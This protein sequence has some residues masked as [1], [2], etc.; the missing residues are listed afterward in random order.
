[1]SQTLL[2]NVQDAAVSFG[3]KPL[4]EKLSF[5]ILEGERIC[6]VGK[7][8][9]GKTTLMNI[10]TGVKD[11]VEGV[12]WQMPGSVFGYLR[13]EVIPVPGQTV[14]E[15]IFEELQEKIES[16]KYKIEMV[17]QPLELDIRDRMDKLSG[18]Q[19]RRAAFSGSFPAIR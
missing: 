3:K 1:M 16:N 5:N 7:N 6:L 12:R 14:Y 17:V 18:G 15:Y 9:A 10:G 2:L 8:G 4:F 13:Q 19:L 11:L